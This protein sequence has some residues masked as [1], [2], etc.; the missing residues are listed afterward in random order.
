MTLKQIAGIFI[1]IC[2]LQ[3]CWEGITESF[4]CNPKVEDPN[5]EFDC[6]CR[7]WFR[8]NLKD[9]DSMQVISESEIENTNGLMKKTVKYRAKNGFGGYVIGM[10]TF[11]MENGNLRAATGSLD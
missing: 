1:G 5:F 8:D 11:R 9:Y 4:G 2:F 3:G 6:T 10:T 7:Q